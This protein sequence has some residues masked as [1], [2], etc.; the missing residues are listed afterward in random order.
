MEPCAPSCYLS[1]LAV[2]VTD[3]QIQKATVRSAFRFIHPVQSM[4]QLSPPARPQNAGK[5]C[6]RNSAV[7]LAFVIYGAC[8]QTTVLFLTTI[9]VSLAT[10]KV[11]FS[12]AKRGKFCT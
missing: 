11:M 5:F 2:S 8:F 6:A 9:Q 10:Q 1:I 3:F 4:C 12:M 7:P